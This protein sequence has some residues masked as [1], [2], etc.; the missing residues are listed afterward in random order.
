MMGVV[1]AIAAAGVCT[2]LQTDDAS[3]NPPITVENMLIHAGSLESVEQRG[4]TLIVRF[5]DGFDAETALGVDSR[6]FETTLDDGQ[7]VRNI[8]QFANVPTGEGGVRV[9]VE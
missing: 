1:V 6:V 7:D 3:T 9:S 2:V 4:R 5:Q 8:L